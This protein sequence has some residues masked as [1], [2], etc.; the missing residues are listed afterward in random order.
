MTETSSHSSTLYLDELSQALASSATEF[1]RKL[2]EILFETL[3]PEVHWIRV[4]EGLDPSDWQL[5][6]EV[7][8]LAL[9]DWP[10]STAIWLYYL[11]LLTSRSVDKDDGLS[12]AQ[13]TELF[14]RALSQTSYDLREVT[15]LQSCSDL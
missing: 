5:R 3:L 14:S 7:M 10:R 12:P 11:Q 1:K 2:G 6:Q 4:L 13:R 8:Q 15:L 9:R